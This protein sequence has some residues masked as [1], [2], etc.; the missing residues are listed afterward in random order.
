MNEKSCSTGSSRL[1]SIMRNRAKSQILL[2]AIAL[3]AIIIVM[4]FATDRFYQPKN[5]LNILTQ[6]TGLGIAAAGAAVVMI[7]GGIDLTLG[8]V[9]SLSGCSTAALMGMG[10][11]IEA[12]VL[13]GVLVAIGCGAANGTLI[14][15]SK[16]EPFIITL[17]M[18]SVYQGLTLVV[19][20]GN[21]LAASPDFTFGRDKLF[22]VVP[23][24]VL[25]LISVFVVMFLVLKF[26]K[27]GRRAYAIGNNT[28]AA[29]LSGI[30][31]KR[32]KIYVYTL[33]GGLLG[34]AAMILLSRLSSGNS[35]MGDSLLMQAIA[36]AVIGGVSMSGGRGSIWGVFL[37]TV[38]IGVISNALNLLSVGAFYQ[39]IVLG[40]IIVGAVFASNAGSKS[41]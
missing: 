9:I 36:A 2:L 13:A 19:T 18:M 25:F 41:R 26:T 11:S 21:N 23:I 1:Q 22:E 28:E 27:F 30:K 35:V 40:G 34:T 4:C 15:L 37:G 24:P 16:A 29:Y 7:S 14:V 17:G 39:S 10:F 33:N 32:N 20:G 6:I 5:V 38:M 3:A 12:S 8:A 31:I